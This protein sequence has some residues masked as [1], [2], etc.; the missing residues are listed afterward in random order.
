MPK[1]N[2]L[3][4]GMMMKKS[5]HD[6]D[7]CFWYK[8]KD[9]RKYINDKYPLKRIIG[10]DGQVF[11]PHPNEFFIKW[12]Q[13][14]NFLLVKRIQERV[15][16]ASKMIMENPA[17]T[18]DLIDRRSYDNLG[19]DEQKGL[20]LK[21]EIVKRVKL[22]P[23]RQ[24]RLMMAMIRVEELLQSDN[25][26]TKR[27]IFYLDKD[28]Y[29]NNQRISDDIID[30]IACEL[31]IPRCLLN[32]HSTPKGQVYGDLTWT[33]VEGDVISC[34]TPNGVFMTVP[35]YPSQIKAM[36]KG[37]LVKFILV[38]EK[39]ATFLEMIT[40]SKIHD[41]M[42][43]ILITGKGYPEYQ[44]KQ[45][46][47]LMW[48]FLRLPIFCVC[49][50]DPGGI[51]IMCMYRFGSLAMAYDSDN[52][53]TPSIRWLGLLP[54]D[55]KRLQVDQVYRVPLTAKDKNKMRD[56]KKL[57]FM[58][59]NPQLLQEIDILEKLDYKIEL[60]AL[61]SINPN[62]LSCRYIQRKICLGYWK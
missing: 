56:L 34:Q 36:K 26:K 21:K 11:N 23:E 41:M 47:H 52:L 49:D 3:V 2:V 61:Q 33:T 5:I 40:R 48:S 12:S 1:A 8:V 27:E 54:S 44:T 24:M 50:G 29:K 15:C 14:D 32:V 42:D 58:A 30:D 53:V 46:I 13:E 7:H 6:H 18:D 59:K 43:C 38:V 51:D 35:P 39:E 25:N 31:R 57:P 22:T 37:S 19:F 55:F 9:H 10:K 4:I 60:Q 16:H 20:F 45:F 62:F 28:L 17:W